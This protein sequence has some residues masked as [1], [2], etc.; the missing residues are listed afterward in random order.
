MT[1]LRAGQTGVRIPAQERYFC[2][3]P[4]KHEWALGGPPNVERVKIGC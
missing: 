4:K 2:F 3:S 1:K